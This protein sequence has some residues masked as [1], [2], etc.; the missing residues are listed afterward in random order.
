MDLAQNTSTVTDVR[1]SG[2]RM[3]SPA[4]LAGALAVVAVAS[5]LAVSLITGGRVDIGTTTKVDPLTGPAAIQFRADE[6]GASA[7]QA[8]PL[9]GPAAIQFRADEHGTT[10]GSSDPLLSTSAI[11]FR[12]SEHEGSVAR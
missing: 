4:F 5:I 12:A 2:T 1:T 9:T 7:V 3:G 10:S 11:E 8:D 6:H